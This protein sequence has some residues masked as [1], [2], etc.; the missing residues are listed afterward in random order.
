MFYALRDDHGRYIHRAAT[1]SGGYCPIYTDDIKYARLWDEE[2][3]AIKTAKNWNNYLEKMTIKDE[4]KDIYCQFN[5]SVGW[6]NT[7][8]TDPT[9][10]SVV[11]LELSLVTSPVM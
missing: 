2:N 8:Q 1:F 3:S 9:S 7:N 4:V 10:V 11:K 5:P 6:T